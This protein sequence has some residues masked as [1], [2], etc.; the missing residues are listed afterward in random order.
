MF[1][2]NSHYVSKASVKHRIKPRMR[3]VK[4]VLQLIVSEELR[5]AFFR[6]AKELLLCVFVT[7]NKL[8]SSVL[9]WPRKLSC[10]FTDDSILY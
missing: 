4:V 8:M 2:F 1:P 5:G 6:I 7:T 10:L 3:A 9:P